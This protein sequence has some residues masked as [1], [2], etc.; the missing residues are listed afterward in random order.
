MLYAV[1][2]KD[3]PN[4]TPLRDATR[5]THLDYLQKDGLSKGRPV[6]TGPMLGADEATPIGSLMVVE[7]ES[8]AAIE[9]WAAGDPY[10]KAGLFESV[11]IRPFRKVIG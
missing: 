4:S 11:E 8:R 6:F 3:K 1:I 9:E 5:P 10:A 7:A 2:C